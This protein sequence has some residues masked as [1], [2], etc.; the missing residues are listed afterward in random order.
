M[1]IATGEESAEPLDEGE[2]K[3][4]LQRRSGPEAL[5]RGMMP[6]WLRRRQEA[7]RL[8]QAD[9]VVADQRPRR[10]GLYGGSPARARCGAG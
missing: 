4:Q 1:G 8:A 5:R 3:E 10:G 7:H 6:Q 2:G 9:A